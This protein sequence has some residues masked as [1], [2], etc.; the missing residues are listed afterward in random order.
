MF[1]HCSKERCF[2]FRK[3]SLHQTLTI[4][5]DTLVSLLWSWAS[6]LNW[7][8]NT[9]RWKTA[10][11]VSSSLSLVEQRGQHHSPNFPFSEG[12]RSR[13]GAIPLLKV[14]KWETR[15][16]NPLMTDPPP[17]TSSTLS[18]QKYIYI[19]FFYFFIICDTWLVTGD[20]WYVTHDSISAL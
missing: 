4:T 11:F 9:N 10:H 13:A 6:R 19:Y 17:T 8:T 3:A 14:M 2:Y 1:S 16:G 20:T 15:W 7:L 18:K 5:Q 12:I